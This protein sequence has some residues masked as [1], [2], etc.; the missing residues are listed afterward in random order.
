MLPYFLTFVKRARCRSRYVFLDHVMC[1]RLQQGLFV[2]VEWTVSQLAFCFN[3]RLVSSMS[4]ASRFKMR[5]TIFFLISV[6][7]SF[8]IPKTPCLLKEDIR[9]AKKH[10]PKHWGWRRHIEVSA[11]ATVMSLTLAVSAKVYVAPNL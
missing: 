9:K 1:Y 8:I 4:L 2:A 11:P 3:W 10:P 6:N 7:Y 5:K